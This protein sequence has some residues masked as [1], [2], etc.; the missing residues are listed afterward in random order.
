MGIL[1]RVGERAQAE[2]ILKDTF[3]TALERIST[4][5][6]PAAQHLSLAAADRFFTK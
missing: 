2:D 4:Y 3:V 5:T 6:F 1:G